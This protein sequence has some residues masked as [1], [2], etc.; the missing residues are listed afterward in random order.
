MKRKTL[1]ILGAIVA[2]F[3]LVLFVLQAQS[4]S[5]RNITLKEILFPQ[6]APA[7]IGQA[8][9]IT[10]ESIEPTATVFPEGMPNPSTQESMWV[11]ISPEQMEKNKKV[12]A[13]A[14]E[15]L[16]NAEKTYLISGWLHIVQRTETFF[17]L[18]TTMPDG[19]PVPTQWEDN[20]WYL[21]DKNGYV[22]QAVS[23]QNTGTEA[24][25]QTST[26]K[27]GVWNNLA[28]KVRPNSNAVP[29]RVPID[30]GFLQNAERG[31]AENFT[32][33][34]LEYTEDT[35]G[36]QPAITFTVTQKMTK[37]VQVADTGHWKIGVAR[38]Y[39]FSPTSGM[40]LQ[41]E[42]YD[43]LPDGTYQL[44]RR[45]SVTLVETVDTPPAEVLGHLK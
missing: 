24:I 44:L 12:V 32:G 33:A 11:T 21:Q 8:T 41:V 7:Q 14:R 42:Q 37:P 23:I 17:S 34:A 5:A 27:D 26:F 9:P 18:S 20:L 22:V 25:S 4:A 29:F 30:G 13:I 3:T 40:L 38:K 6:I 1:A 39:S 43:I 2:M 35:V 31:I 19:S 28:L 45:I 15:L 16:G 36:D 10:T